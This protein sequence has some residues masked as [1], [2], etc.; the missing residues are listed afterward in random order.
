MLGTLLSA[1]GAGFLAMLI[2]LG[3]GWGL[4]SSHGGSGWGG[5]GGGFSGGGGGFGG[6]SASGRW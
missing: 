3:V 6:G 1:L 2:N 4:L 5:G